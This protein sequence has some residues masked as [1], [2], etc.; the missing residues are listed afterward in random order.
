MAIHPSIV[1][2]QQE[3]KA[4]FKE[5]EKL[6]PLAENEMAAA[7]QLV[8]LSDDG[9]SEK[10]RLDLNASPSHSPSS[11]SYSADGSSGTVVEEKNPSA[12]S[13]PKRR[14]RSLS[15]IYRQ[16]RP[17]DDQAMRKRFKC[18]EQ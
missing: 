15:S 14:F 17:I 6:K 4:G 1:I 18:R 9:E 7:K 8:Q 16:T 2:Q 5:Q 3:R 11:S 12:I 13:K 10:I